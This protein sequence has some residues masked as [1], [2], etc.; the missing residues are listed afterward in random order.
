MRALALMLSS[1]RQ[2]VAH[3]RYNS[4]AA[5]AFSLLSCVSMARHTLL[6]E[7]VPS[8]LTSSYRLPTYT[9][10]SDGSCQPPLPSTAQAKHKQ[11][12]KLKQPRRPTEPAKSRA[13]HNT[14]QAR[15]KQRARRP[16]APSLAPVPYW[17]CPSCG[18]T[19]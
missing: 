7:P 14:C 10:D 3:D 18:S 9:S 2:R 11:F 4:P 19:T 15:R 5:L 13:A 1:Q 8:T 17:L 6:N 12:P 16:L